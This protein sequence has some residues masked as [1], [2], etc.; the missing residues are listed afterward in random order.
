[1]TKL[2]ENAIAECAEANLRKYRVGCEHIAHGGERIGIFYAKKGASQRP[3]GIVY[4]RKHSAFSTSEPED[5]DWNEILDGAGYF[6]FTGITPALGGKL[7]EICLEA[8]E[9]AKKLGVTVSCD[10]N[11]RKNLWSREDAKRTIDLFD[12]PP[13]LSMKMPISSPFSYAEVGLSNRSI[14][15]LLSSSFCTPPD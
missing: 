11:Y 15:P 2:P 8:C 4:D 1:M 7:P 12:N 13:K 10:L 5:Y 3:S 6:H 14:I 9:T